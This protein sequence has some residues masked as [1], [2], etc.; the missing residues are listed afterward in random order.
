[1]FLVY[2]YVYIC[3]SIHFA[4]MVSLAGHVW[5]GVILLSSSILLSSKLYK[6]QRGH[7]VEGNCREFP[8]LRFISYVTNDACMLERQNSRSLQVF[9][10]VSLFSL[11]S[12]VALVFFLSHIRV[13][14]L[15]LGCAIFSFLLTAYLFS[16][17]KCSRAA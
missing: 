11:S 13:V 12:A 4:Y 3:L 5:G 1:M 16:R 9:L 10:F 6:F 17:V 14:G 15:V 7:P 2:F 8:L